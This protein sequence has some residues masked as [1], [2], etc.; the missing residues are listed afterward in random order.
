MSSS[1]IVRYR[2]RPDAAEENARLVGSFGHGSSGVPMRAYEAT[3]LV[4]ATRTRCGRS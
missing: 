1:A 3:S 2:T 4:E